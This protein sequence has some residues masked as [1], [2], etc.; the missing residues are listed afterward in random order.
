MAWLTRSLLSLK[1][2]LGNSTNHAVHTTLHGTWYLFDGARIF[3]H[4]DATLYSKYLSRG[5]EIRPSL[6]AL[7]EVH[8][9]PFPYTC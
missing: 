3:F 9:K 1:T 2:D 8:N 6:Y 4:N 7:D 5:R